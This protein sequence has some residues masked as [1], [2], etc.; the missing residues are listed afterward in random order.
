MFDPLLVL[1]GL[2]VGLLIGFSGMGGGALMTP[3]LIFWFNVPPVL[4]VGTDLAYSA[5]TKA[6]GALQHLKKGNVDRRLALRLAMG[7]IP[8]A[9]LAVRMTEWMKAG[10]NL[11]LDVVIKKSL[12]VI[13]IFVG[14]LIL[15]QILRYS[16]RSKYAPKKAPPIDPGMRNV[17]D[18]AAAFVIGF[19]VG[20]TSVGSG[21][22]VVAWLSL[23]HLLPGRVV[24]G[25]DL[26]NAF[27]LTAAAALAHFQFGNIDILLMLNLLLGSIPGILMGTHLTLRVPNQA[28]RGCLATIL[29]AIG[30]QL[31]RQ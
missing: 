1:L 18:I 9:L 3:S 13:L 22:L 21:S 19:L 29:L 14:G 7:S 11:N 8:G 27:L 17:L 12:G 10:E 26:S 5:I 24:V 16:G 2:V 28:L 23:T 15:I 31:F 6:F 4:A 30:V 20:L 25:T